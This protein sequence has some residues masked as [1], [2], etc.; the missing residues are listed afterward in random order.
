MQSSAF[1]VM[2][3]IDD[4]ANPTRAHDCEDCNQRLHGLRLD[5]PIVELAN[6]L[7]DYFYLSVIT[8]S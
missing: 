7:T 6:P 1:R 3:I 8:L 2:G 5:V 4:K